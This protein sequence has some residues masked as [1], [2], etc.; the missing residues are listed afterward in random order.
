MDSALNPFTPNRDRFQISPAASPVILHHTVWRT[1]LFVTYSDERWLYYYFSLPH[2]YISFWGMGRMLK[3]LTRSPTPA[4]GTRLRPDRKRPWSRW[5][6]AASGSASRP[7]TEGRYW[8]HVTDMWSCTWINSRGKHLHMTIHVDRYTWP[9]TW[10]RTRGRT[11]VRRK[12]DRVHG[13]NLHKESFTGK[14][15]IIWRLKHRWPDV[16][17][18]CPRYLHDIWIFMSN[19]P[20]NGEQANTQEC[21]PTRVSTFWMR[22]V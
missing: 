5:S 14:F 11:D 20:E 1:R 13:A 6:C 19:F 2:S 7:G 18:G 15:Q 17:I 4:R 12:R 8:A 10:T 16:S 3:E 9:N 22:G 21:W